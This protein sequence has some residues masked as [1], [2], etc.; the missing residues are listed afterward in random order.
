MFIA[1]DQARRLVVGGSP[2]LVYWNP[3]PDH[4]Y[5]LVAGKGSE[6]GLLFIVLD[7]GRGRRLRF[8][9]TLEKDTLTITCKEKVRAG[10]WLGDC[11]ISGS[12]VRC[13]GTYK[14]AGAGRARR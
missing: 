14:K 1:K 4:S 2:P 8:E 11:D 12:W 6:K 3:W 10:H 5:D 13:N 7:K 9:Y